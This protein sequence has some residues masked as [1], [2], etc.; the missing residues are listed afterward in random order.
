MKIHGS[1]LFAAIGLTLVT[2][3]SLLAA[4]GTDL[5]SGCNDVDWPYLPESDSAYFY[6][7]DLAQTLVDHR[8]I[9]TCISPSKMAGTF[10]GQEGAAVYRTNEGDFE[11]LFMPKPQNLIRLRVIERHDRRRYLYSFAGRPKPWPANL[12]DSAFPLYFVKHG[13]ELIVAQDQQV[14]ARVKDAL[15]DR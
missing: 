1:L 2:Q 4:G 5:F 10:E 7:I 11:A 14:A 12:I 6:A 13:N 8:F 9:V 15:D 3:P